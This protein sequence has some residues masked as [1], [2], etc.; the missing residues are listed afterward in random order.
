MGEGDFSLFHEPGIRSH[1]GYIRCIVMRFQ[2]FHD[3][4]IRKMAFAAEYHQSAGPLLLKMGDQP[5]YN[6]KHLLSGTPF[7]RFQNRCNKLAAQSFINMEGHEAS[8]A[9]ISVKERV[10]LTAADAFFGFAQQ[11]SS[12]IRCERAAVKVHDNRLVSGIGEDNLFK[13]FFSCIIMRYCGILIHI[14][15]SFF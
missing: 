11:K 15:F 14:L 2:T 5:L 12:G 9:V 7:S 8:V 10:L 3:F 4:R 13:V 1:A 6:R